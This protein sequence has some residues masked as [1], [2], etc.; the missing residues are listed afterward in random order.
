VCVA[1]VEVGAAAEAVFAAAVSHSHDGRGYVGGEGEDVP[2][3]WGC[4][5]ALEALAVVVNELTGSRDD[6]GIRRCGGLLTA[7]SF[8]LQVAKFAVS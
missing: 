6:G 8:R 4:E 7:E 1:A 2:G 5:H 3:G